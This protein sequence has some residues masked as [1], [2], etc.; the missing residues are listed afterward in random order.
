MSKKKIVPP[1]SS[2]CLSNSCHHPLVNPQFIELEHNSGFWNRTTPTMTS[3]NPINIF[4]KRQF[5]NN[6][7]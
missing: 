6:S 4:Q 1:L 3:D 5:N 7:N 2:G